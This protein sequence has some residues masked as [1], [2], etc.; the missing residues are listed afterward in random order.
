MQRLF[1][2]T[3]QGRVATLLFT[4]GAAP[5]EALE[6]LASTDAV[7]SK[8]TWLSLD[9]T[10]SILYSTEGGTGGGQGALKS[11]TIRPDG[12]LDELASV[13]IPVSAASQM[14]FRGGNTMT[15]PF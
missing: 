9:K 8:P 2:S 3:Y 4:P 10:R 14:L 13:K 12:S 15:I 6:E 1:L 11:F 7:G 5:T